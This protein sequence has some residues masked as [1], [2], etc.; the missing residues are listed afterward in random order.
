MAAFPPCAS[1]PGD[2]A[3]VAHRWMG[4]FGAIHHL[5]LH[6]RAPFHVFQLPKVQAG[7]GKDAHE[8]QTRPTHQPGGKSGAYGAN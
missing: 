6:K 3:H 8:A 4:R 7:D 2:P 1:R 5:A